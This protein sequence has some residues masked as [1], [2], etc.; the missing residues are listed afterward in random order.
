MMFFDGV[1]L[2]A[3]MRETLERRS[4]HPDSVLHVV[5]SLVQTSLRGVDSHGI[6]LFPHYCR[7]LDAGRINGNPSMSME[8][9]GDGTA[10]LDADHAPGHHAGAVAMDKAI[11]LAKR[12]GIGA[13]AVKNST[14]FGAAAYF[15]LRAPAHDCLG[16]AFTNADALVKVHGGRDAFF[17][18]NPICFTAPLEREESFCLDMA[19]SLVSWNK[20]VNHRRENLP[21]PESWAF[22]AAGTGVTDPNRAATLNPAG[23]Y[24]GYGLGMMVD[25][26]CGVLS[27]GPVGREIRAMYAPPLDES[28]RRVGHFFVAVEIGRFLDPA[29][30]RARLQAIV[31][32]V[33]RMAPL[34]QGDEVMVA[35]DPEK[36]AKD[37]RSREGIPVDEGKYK[38][39]LGLSPAFKEALVRETACRRRQFQRGRVLPSIGG[40]ARRAVPRYRFRLLPLAPAVRRPG[41]EDRPGTDRGIDCGHRDLEPRGGRPDQPEPRHFRDHPSSVRA[42]HRPASD[43]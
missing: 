3:A 20:I 35:G 2:A 11:E 40:M 32:S 38:E 14:H 19:T 31:D 39:F 17:G 8:R 23:G 1:R 10:L 26:L 25:I 28:K 37:R 29:S 15:G 6:N 41:K 21:I 12:C 7:A 18:T 13:V 43:R 34:S 42:R 24:K 33:R 5:S 9:T 27:G 22:D 16:L 4:V 30:F 36:R